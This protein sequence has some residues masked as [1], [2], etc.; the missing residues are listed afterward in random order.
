MTID[1]LKLGQSA[2][3]IRTVTQSDIDRFAD[4]SGDRNPVHLDPGYAANTPFQGVIAHGML[5]ASFISAIIGNTLPGKG[6]IYL[7]QSLRFLAPVR[8]GDEVKT[9]VS[10]SSITPEKRRVI[11][12]TSCYVGQTKVIDGEATILVAS[13]QQA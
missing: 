1:E 8:P 10:I 11:C 12:S 4:V 2:T 7:G 13:G 3:S 6:S 9:I 5:S